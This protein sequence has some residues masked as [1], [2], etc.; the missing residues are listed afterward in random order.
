MCFEEILVK[1][2]PE[3][4]KIT[5]KLNGHFTFFDEDDLFQEALINLWENFKKGKLQNKT[6]SYI[7]QGCYFH[8]KNYI[9]KNKKNLDL[10]SFDNIFEEET[11]PVEPENSLEG[12]IFLE[13]IRKNGLTSREKYIL[14][15]FLEGFTVREIGEKLGLSHVSVIKIKNKIKN[16]YGHGYQK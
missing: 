2:T 13:T 12:K 15:L 16:K 5:H 1:I 10:W 7:L 11:M 9:R 8:L 14:T 4:K 6:K 3:L